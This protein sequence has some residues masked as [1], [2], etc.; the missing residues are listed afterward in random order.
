M[1]HE[2]V[3][4][5]REGLAADADLETMFDRYTA[6]LQNWML[7]LV[8]AQTALILIIAVGAIVVAG[9]LWG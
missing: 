2:V 9:V 1:P 8:L 3:Q 5:A 4:D 6:R 7:K